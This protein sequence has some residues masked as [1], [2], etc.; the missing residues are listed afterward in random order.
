MCFQELNALLLLLLLLLLSPGPAVK[1]CQA[2]PP[3]DTPNS[4]QGWDPA[5]AGKKI[6]QTCT[7]PCGQKAFGEG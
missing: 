5:C 7:A 3:K 1:S 6:G 2:V 4:Q